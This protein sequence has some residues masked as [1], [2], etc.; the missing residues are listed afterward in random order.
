MIDN[1]TDIY[2]SLFKFKFV[3]LQNVLLN[4]NV[5]CHLLILIWKLLGLLSLSREKKIIWN[6]HGKFNTEGLNFLIKIEF[7]EMKNFQNTGFN[8]SEI[9]VKWFLG[10]L[11]EKYG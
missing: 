2:L 1:Y 7:Q 6:G 9:A 8:I 11:T 4:S 10:F 5:T 3:E